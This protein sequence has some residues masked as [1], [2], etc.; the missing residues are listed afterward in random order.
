M[1]FRISKYAHNAW[2]APQGH[3][4]PQVLIMK[5]T[6]YKHMILIALIFPSLVLSYRFL[7]KKLIEE[8]VL[9]KEKVII[10]LAKI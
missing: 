6:S 4:N 3:K 7:A 9:I 10:F 8:N 2:K 5:R 1:T